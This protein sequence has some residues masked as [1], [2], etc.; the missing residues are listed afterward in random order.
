MANEFL[1]LQKR[2]F[3]LFGQSCTANKNSAALKVLIIFNIIV[4]ALIMIGTGIYAI[5]NSNDIQLV[6]DALAPVFTGILTLIKGTTFVLN[7]IYFLNAINAI[8]KMIQPCR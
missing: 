4:P 5:E 1:S 3:K 7:K 8:D 2:V 6:T